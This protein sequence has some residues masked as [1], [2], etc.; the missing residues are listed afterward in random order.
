MNHS[1]DYGFHLGGKTTEQGELLKNWKAQTITLKQ[2]DKI[3]EI[4]ASP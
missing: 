3:T 4:L 2:T 1:D